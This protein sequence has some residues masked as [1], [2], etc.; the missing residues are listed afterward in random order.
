MLK[1][2]SSLGARL[3]GR[4]PGNDDEVSLA[5]HT[6]ATKSC[7]GGAWE[8]EYT[9]DLFSTLYKIEYCTGRLVKSE[10][11]AMVLLEKGFILQCKGAH[12]L[13]F[14]ARA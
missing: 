11:E 8:R 6:E 4:S 14:A 7:M 5:F 1:L 10:N 12:F 3:A 2:A 9:G 13:K